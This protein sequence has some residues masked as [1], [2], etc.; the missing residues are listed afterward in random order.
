[1]P[2]PKCGS[3]DW[4]M[5]S[6]IHAAVKKGRLSKLTAPPKLPESD[7]I[8]VEW[9]FAMF[10]GIFLVVIIV[11]KGITGIQAAL[12]ASSFILFIPSDVKS[13]KKQT[14]QKMDEYLLQKLRYPSKKMCLRCEAF[15]F[16]CQKPTGNYKTYQ[17]TTSRISLPKN[18]N[19]KRFVSDKKK[20]VVDN[21]HESL[22]NLFN[23]KKTDANLDAVELTKKCP[24]CA[25][26]I[27]SEAVICR[28]CHKEQQ[29]VKPPLPP[30]KPNKSIGN[31]VT[32]NFVKFPKEPTIFPKEPS[33]EKVK[34]QPLF[35]D[36][37]LAALTKLFKW[38]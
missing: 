34:T 1:M 27:K 4:K 10:F 15:F 20:G 3:D 36:P 28:F 25:E 19:K 21:S 32:H 29:V 2:C 23:H 31:N 17:P 16:N 13:K 26:T 22:S 30:V 38:K 14:K 8:F 9:F 6:V 11:I 24:F 5:A 7:S 35:Q 33:I 12:I 18:Q 37:G